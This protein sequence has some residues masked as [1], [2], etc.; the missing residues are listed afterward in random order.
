VT[1]PSPEEQAR[2]KA[3]KEAKRAAKKAKFGAINEDRN[4]PTIEVMLPLN[5]FY[6]DGADKQFYEIEL[7]YTDEQIQERCDHAEQAFRLAPCYVDYW[8]GTDYTKKY[9]GPVKLKIVRYYSDEDE[10]YRRLYGQDI[11]FHKRKK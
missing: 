2:L 5:R 6:R 4:T 10:T 8:P 7:E 1:R 3:E 11:V 9:L